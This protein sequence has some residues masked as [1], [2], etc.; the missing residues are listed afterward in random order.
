MCCTKCWGYKD[1]KDSHHLQGACDNAPRTDSIV[2][3]FH[4][5]LQRSVTNVQIP[6]FGK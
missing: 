6:V 5:A 4:S 2:E 1:E 3:G